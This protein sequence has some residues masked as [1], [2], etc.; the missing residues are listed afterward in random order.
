MPPRRLKLGNIMRCV[1]LGQM[2]CDRQ[3]EFDLPFGLR[4][5]FITDE[6][7]PPLGKGELQNL[8]SVMRSLV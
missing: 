8:M 6:K 3:A 2:W 1:E 4:P 7:R 5:E